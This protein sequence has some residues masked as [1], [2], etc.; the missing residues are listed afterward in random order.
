MLGAGATH[1]FGAVL[2]PRQKMA[3]RM[4]KQMSS[5]TLGVAAFS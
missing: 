5:P 2:V 4:A 1:P 3:D